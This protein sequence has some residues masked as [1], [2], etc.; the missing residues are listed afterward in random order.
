[1][2]ILECAAGHES[3]SDSLGAL[4]AI[5]CGRDRALHFGGHD[6]C[7]DGCSAKRAWPAGH[8]VC[9]AFRWD[10]SAGV[11][12]AIDRLSAAARDFILRVV[13]IVGGNRTHHRA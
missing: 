7:K 11:S 6:L 10:S 5:D 8:W 4:R 3:V 13:F 9:D 1:M 12:T 2:P